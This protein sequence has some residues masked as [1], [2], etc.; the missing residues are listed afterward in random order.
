LDAL[1]PLATDADKAFL[2]RA[3]YLIVIFAERYR[4]EPDGTRS[5]NYY[6]SEVVGY[7]AADAQVPV[8]S[9]KSLSEI[10]TFV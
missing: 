7:P 4:L 10:A 5:K 2:E 1:A 6:V 8:I 9:K 3:P